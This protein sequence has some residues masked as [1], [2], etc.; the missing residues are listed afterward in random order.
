MKRFLLAI[1]AAIF[2]LTTAASAAMFSATGSGGT[3]DY[4]AFSP[5][6]PPIG[7]SYSF[8]LMF[9][10]TGTGFVATFSNVSGSI[11]VDGVGSYALNDIVTAGVFGNFFSI[12]IDSD[13]FASGP[14]TSGLSNLRLGL[15][16]TGNA[17]TTPVADL[18]ADAT[19]NFFTLTFQAL[20][21][22]DQGAQSSI[23]T[24]SIGPTATV[25]L[26]ATSLLLLAGLGGLA[27]VRRR[28]R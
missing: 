28:T 6:A 21:G 19:L 26:P 22:Q 11:S 5:D 1:A 3:G 27:A 24:F 7:T 25:P 8:D 12:L 4:G 9:D 18:L 16:V 10:V 14:G 15:N 13:D 17:N 23:S 20:D 2:S